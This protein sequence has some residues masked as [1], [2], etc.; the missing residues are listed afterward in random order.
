VQVARAVDAQAHQLRGQ[1]RTPADKEWQEVG[2]C[3]LPAK[4][5]PKISLQCYQGP[6]K[7]ERWV[8]ISDFRVSQKKP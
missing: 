4:G 1:F 8:R 6:A 3:D 5:A 7:V 2:E